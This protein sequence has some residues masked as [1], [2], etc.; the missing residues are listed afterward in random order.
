MAVELGTFLDLPKR[1][2]PT[3]LVLD[4]GGGIRPLSRADYVLD[5]LSWKDRYAVGPWLN[6]VW[7][8]PCACATGSWWSMRGRRKPIS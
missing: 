2:R 5:F 7:P 4:I 3:D 6:E 1:I 8:I